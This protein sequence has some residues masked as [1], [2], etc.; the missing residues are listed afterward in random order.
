VKHI[1]KN[2][3]KQNGLRNLL[4]TGAR[5]C[6]VLNKYF[7]Y[8]WLTVINATNFEQFDSFSIY[9]AEKQTHN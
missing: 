9:P 4:T 6:A 8:P 2:T 3:R 1:L 5:N 7:V